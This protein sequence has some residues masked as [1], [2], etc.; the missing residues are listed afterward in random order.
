M[1]GMTT[2]SSRPGLTRAD[3]EAAPDDTHVRS[4]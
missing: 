4:R 2:Q 1:V 3:L